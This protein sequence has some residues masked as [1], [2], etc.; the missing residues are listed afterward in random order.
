MLPWQPK[1]HT[2]SVFIK[3]AYSTKGAYLKQTISFQH[4]RIGIILNLVYIIYICNTNT[5]LKKKNPN[6]SYH[7]NR[8]GQKRF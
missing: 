5:F 8:N 1:H 3:M 6:Y 4:D 2:I 7:G